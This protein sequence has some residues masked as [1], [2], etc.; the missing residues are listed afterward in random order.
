MSER[1]DDV[2][3]H[4]GR[5][6]LIEWIFGGIGL[7]L[8]LAMI[9]FI[10]WQAVSHSSEEPPRIELRIEDVS[11]SGSGYVAEIVAR[12]H[13]RSTA[14]GV[15]VE[16]VLSPGSAESETS[17]LTF[18]YIPGGSTVRG[19]LHFSKNPTAGALQLRTLGHTDP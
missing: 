8:T 17:T 9:G 12:N 13:S 14:K 11:R 7:A 15:E 2:K 5:S 18:D 16:A 1:S 4:P 3:K 19:A 6:P 10:G